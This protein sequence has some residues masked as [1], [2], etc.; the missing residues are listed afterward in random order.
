RA[1]AQ[2]FQAKAAAFV[3]FHH[4]DGNVFREKLEKLVKGL[5]PGLARLFGKASDEIEA[6]IAHANVAKNFCGTIDI[7]AAMHAA[8]GFQ[9]FIDERLRAEADAIDSRCQPVDSFLF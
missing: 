6:D 8:S 2:D 5:A 3:D 4:V 9:F 7:G 1:V